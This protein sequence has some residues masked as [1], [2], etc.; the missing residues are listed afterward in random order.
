MPNEE[1]VPIIASAFGDECVND[2]PCIFGLRVETHSIYCENKDWKDAPRKCRRT[3]YTGGM[4]R[5]EDC[6]GFKKN[7]NRTQITMEKSQ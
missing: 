7:P 3:W 5:D 2:Q 6:P 1:I 4:E